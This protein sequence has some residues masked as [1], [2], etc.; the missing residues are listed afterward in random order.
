[1]RF[2]KNDDSLLALMMTEFYAN[3]KIAY[4]D[5]EPFETF[6]TILRSV[7]S[8]RSR[9][10]NSSTSRRTNPEAVSS[11]TTSHLGDG[12]SITASKSMQGMC[13]GGDDPRIEPPKNFGQR[14]IR[15]LLGLQR[16]P[17]FV[18]VIDSRFLQHIF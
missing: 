4:D 18:L 9:L 10:F 5:K 7:L 17:D 1:M 2:A 11:S 15:A 12:S 6:S 13:S 14:Q 3:R 8:C 16:S